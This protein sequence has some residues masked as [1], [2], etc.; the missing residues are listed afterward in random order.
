M[1]DRVTHWPA[2]KR[3]EGYAIPEIE[4]YAISEIEAH[5]DGLPNVSALDGFPNISALA[6]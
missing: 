5:P 1:Q 3:F 6:E 4:G 2:V